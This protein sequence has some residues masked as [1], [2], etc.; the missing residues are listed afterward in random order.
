MIQITG[1]LHVCCD[2]CGTIT[3][4]RASTLKVKQCQK[5][6][7]TDEETEIVK[8]EHE[9]KCQCGNNCEFMLELWA[10]L[11]QETFRDIADADC[12]VH[13]GPDFVVTIT[14]EVQK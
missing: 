8:F 5:P 12:V 9:H 7:D 2:E 3:D 6:Q 4:V 10:V 1:T 13:E 11:G 14:E